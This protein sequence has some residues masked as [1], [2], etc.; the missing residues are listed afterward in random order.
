[1]S[2]S[3]QT[4]RDLAGQLSPRDQVR[5]ITLLSAQ[6]EAVVMDTSAHSSVEAWTTYDQLR[7]EFAALPGPSTSAVAELSAS[8]R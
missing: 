2:I 3:L 8:R 1:M 5:L 4:V 6:L 7:A